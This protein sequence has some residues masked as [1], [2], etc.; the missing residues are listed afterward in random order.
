MSYYEEAKQ[1][2]PLCAT[3]MISDDFWNAHRCTNPTCNVEWR[4]YEREA[5]PDLDMPGERTIELDDG[6]LVL[7]IEYIE[8]RPI[9]T[10]FTLHEPARKPFQKKTP[11]R[12]TR[13]SISSSL[14]SSDADRI[15]RSLREAFSVWRL[16][17]FV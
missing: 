3:E 9:E 5:D 8:G 10:A 7:R 14:A 15:D 1:T 2:C 4:Y 17:N 13:V 11:P 12:M 16:H 6:R